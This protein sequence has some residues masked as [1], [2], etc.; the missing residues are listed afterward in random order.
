[1]DQIVSNQLV[2]I[3]SDKFSAKTLLEIYNSLWV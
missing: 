2:S 3:E 1:V